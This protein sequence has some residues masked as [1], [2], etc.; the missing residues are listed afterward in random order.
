VDSNALSLVLKNL[1]FT[2]VVPATVAVYL[3]LWLAPEDFLEPLGTPSP[4]KWLA[5]APLAAGLVIYTWCVWD[6]GSH[7]GTPAPV[8]APKRLVVRGL[9]RYVRNPM[10]VG[11]LLLILGWVVW[12]RSSRLLLYAGLIAIAF[13]LF[14]TGYEE[15]TL[16]RRFGSEYQDYAARVNRWLPRLPPG[17]GP[18]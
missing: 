18:S 2:F 7:G 16:R 9:Y 13:H 14:V 3:P 5:I 15:P 10:Y 11:V 17:R 1:L 4:W 6:F 8:D 12:F